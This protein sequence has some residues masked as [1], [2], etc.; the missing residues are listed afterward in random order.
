MLNFELRLKW[1]LAIYKKSV[2]FALQIFEFLTCPS[3]NKKLDFQKRLE[4]FNEK[5]RFQCV[6]LQDGA[7]TLFPP[8]GHQDSCSLWVGELPQPNLDFISKCKNIWLGW[9]FLCWGA[10]RLPFCLAWQ[11]CRG[12][13]GD[14]Q[15][16]QV[17]NNKCIN[18][19]VINGKFNTTFVELFCIFSINCRWT[20]S[21]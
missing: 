17:L 19:H 5:K 8:A 9:T 20:L 18:G 1:T 2:I 16:S 12:K 10:Q 4:W 14:F 11:R 21:M 15:R 7:S 6:F 13:E 3:L